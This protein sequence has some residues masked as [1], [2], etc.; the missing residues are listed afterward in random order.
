MCEK[1]FSAK[2]YS[3]STQK[4][5]VSKMHFHFLAIFHLFHFIKYLIFSKATRWSQ[6]R[7]LSWSEDMLLLLVVGKRCNWGFPKG[8]GWDKIAP[9]SKVMGKQFECA[10]VFVSSLHWNLVVTEFYKNKNVV[11]LFEKSTSVIWENGRSSLP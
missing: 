4:R 7:L 9:N 1:A 10:F 6:P 2:K 11:T 5:F 3:L 8:T